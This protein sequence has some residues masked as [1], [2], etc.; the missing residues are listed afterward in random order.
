MSHPDQ[1]GTVVPVLRVTQLSIQLPLHA[2]VAAGFPSPAEDH[3]EERLDLNGYLIKNPAATFFLRVEGHSMTG[4]GI[5]PD[6][7]LIVDR[8]LEA[9]PNDVI[10]AVLAGEFTLK[11]LVREAGEWYLQAEH[12]DYPRTPLDGYTDFLVWGVVTHVIHRPYPL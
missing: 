4:A 11:R 12:P 3:E 1:T 2:A 10:V 5:Y 7:I 8:S 9:R 6:D